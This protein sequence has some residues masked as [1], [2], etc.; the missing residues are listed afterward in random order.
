MTTA[1]LALQGAFAEHEAMLDALG[2]PWFEL[3]C[4]DDLKRP[5]DRLVLPGGESTTQGRLLRDEGMLEPL[6]ARIE[7][8]IPVLATCAGLILL[9]RRIV[10]SGASISGDTHAP[11]FAQHLATLD[12]TVE[13][14]AYGRQLASF[15]AHAEFAG[16][17]EVP[18]SFIRAPR[19]AEVGDAVEPLARVDGAV[20][21]VRAGAQVACAFHPELDGDTRIHELFLGL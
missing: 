18:M 12:V 2:E 6:K 8:G 16:L 13:R 9:A 15:H 19:I 7:D 1:V 10:E 17:G 21:A 5:F 14:N 3:R 4:G 20:V 11:R